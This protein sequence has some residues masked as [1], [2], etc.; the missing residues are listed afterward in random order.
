MYTENKIKLLKSALLRINDGTAKFVCDGI[1]HAA[2]NYA[3]EHSSAPVYEDLKNL[4]SHLKDQIAESI[5]C[6]GVDGWL[7]TNHTTFYNRLII[8]YNGNEDMAMKKYRSEWLKAWIA[9][10][11]EN[12]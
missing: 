3:W 4:A 5:Q 12:V 6:F 11:E 7:K 9:N 2:G 1:G 10:L 8:E